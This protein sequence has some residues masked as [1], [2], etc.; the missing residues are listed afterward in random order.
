MVKLSTAPRGSARAPL[1]PC[2]LTGRP[3][4][5]MIHGVSAGVIADIWRLGQGVDVSALFKGVDRF[6][7]YESDTGLVFFEPRIVGDGPFY[8]AYYSRWDVHTGLNNRVDERADF[9]MAAKFVPEGATVIDV[10]C[11]PG[12]FR[13]HLP[14]ARFVGLDP[15]AADD[16]DDAVI[17]ET[18]EVHAENNPSVYDVATAFHVIEH[19]PDPLSHVKRMARMLKPGGL[20]VLAAPLHPSPLTRIPNLPVNM[21]PHHVTWWN[22]SAFSALAREAGLEVVEATSLPASPHQGL[23]LWMSKLLLSETDKAP[24]ER[25]FGHR[26]AW[27]ASLVLSY[28]AAKVAFRIRPLPKHSPDI[29][30]FLVA[31]K[32]AA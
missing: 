17:R 7:L 9:A 6:T 19:V 30:A 20:L 1:P 18:L 2:P 29:D 31:R 13:R 21:P 10:G 8:N 4:K 23:I 3:A 28:L 24:A 5:R 16:V 27:H 32:P 14:H 25:Y 26:W 11:G 12:L 22:P 15:Y